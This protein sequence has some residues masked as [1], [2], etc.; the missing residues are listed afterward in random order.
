[1]SSI[2]KELLREHA[3]PEIRNIEM[4]RNLSQRL[5][6]LPHQELCKVQTAMKTSQARTKSRASRKKAT[7]ASVQVKLAMKVSLDGPAAAQMD[8]TMG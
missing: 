2:W 1:M 5:A 3:Q 4:A 8:V 6:P 7:K